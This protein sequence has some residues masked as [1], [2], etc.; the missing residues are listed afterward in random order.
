MLNTNS[1]FCIRKYK[2]IQSYIQ[3]IPLSLIIGY[4]NFYVFTSIL[5]VFYYINGTQFNLVKNNSC[6]NLYS[7]IFNLHKLLYIPLSFVVKLFGDMIKDKHLDLLYSKISI[8]SFFNNYYN[9][10]YPHLISVYD[11]LYDTKQELNIIMVFNFIYS[12]SYKLAVI[13]IFGFLCSVVI[14]FGLN[15][16]DYPREVFTIKQFVGDTNHITLHN[17]IVKLITTIFSNVIILSIYNYG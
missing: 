9:R 10:I 12:N 17:L 3:N 6:R 15:I 4:F 13:F 7:K 1:I 11:K 2:I 14:S 5:E 16:C 8:F